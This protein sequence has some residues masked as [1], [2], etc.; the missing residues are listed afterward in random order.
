[1]SVTLEHHEAVLRRRCHNGRL[2]RNDDKLAD[3]LGIES[4]EVQA[5]L[6]GLAAAGVLLPEGT[7]SRGSEMFSFVGLPVM[8]DDARRLYETM[9]T[10]ATVEGVVN[11]VNAGELG[12]AAGMPEHVVKAAYGDLKRLRL[13][14]EGTF[15][16]RRF[17][18][19]VR[20]RAVGVL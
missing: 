4:T 14:R 1:V 2:Y 19:L 13:V 8:P 7:S 17:P 9:L 18:V 20:Q 5:V 16:D 10:L 12:E 3:W 15:G 11:A 6:D